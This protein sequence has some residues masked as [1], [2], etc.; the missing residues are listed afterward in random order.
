MGLLIILSSKV[1]HHDTVPAECL[2]PDCLTP[3]PRHRTPT[4]SMCWPLSSLHY[5]LQ[6]EEWGQ[7]LL[8]VHLWCNF[9]LEDIQRNKM[10]R[11]ICL[12]WGHCSPE[13]TY[14]GQWQLPPH[15]CFWVT[16]FLLLSEWSCPSLSYS[17][18]PKYA[19]HTRVRTH[20]HVCI[21]KHTY[22]IHTYKHTYVVKWQN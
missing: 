17:S 13:E 7:F 2:N 1:L 22:S 9:T 6:I 8:L 11:N 4:Q 21:Y 16:W 10:Q 5:G 20:T 3:K 18:M 14:R 12:F 19:S 15:L